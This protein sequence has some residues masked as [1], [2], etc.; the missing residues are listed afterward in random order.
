MKVGLRQVIVVCGVFLLLLTGCHHKTP[1]GDYDS[2]EV[3]QVKKVI[4]GT[5]LS[6]RAVR[7][8]NKTAETG[9]T[10]STTKN[11]NSWL[12]TSTSGSHGFEYV[13]RLNNGTIISVV[14]A[15]AVKLK[16]K[17]HVLVIYGGNTRV[18]PDKGTN[19]Y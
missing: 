1:E 14:Q 5:I 9:V 18:V 6:M 10:T 19:S 15:D 2:R 16:V 12:H 7:L 11:D 17:Q 13:V 4:P 8:H 3:G